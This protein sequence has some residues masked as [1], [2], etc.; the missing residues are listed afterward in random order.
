MKL[1][2]KNI[3]LMLLGSGLFSCNSNT[4]SPVKTVRAD[5]ILPN[6]IVHDTLSTEQIAQIKKIHSTFAEVNPSTLD[7]TITNFQRDQNPDNEISTWLSM[8]FA[9]EKFLGAK[10]AMELSKKREVYKLVLLR[11]MMDAAQAKH[12]AASQI[13]TTQEIDEILSYYDKAPS[14]LKVSR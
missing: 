1:F 4:G 14:P 11:S 7:E 6:R 12:Q 5:Q 10:P 3:Y 8:A 13:L 9:Y 2:A